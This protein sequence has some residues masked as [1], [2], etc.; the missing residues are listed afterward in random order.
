MAAAPALDRIDFAIIGLL[1]DNGRLS[2]KEIGAS[3]GLAPSSA[4]AR[5]R[6]LREAGVLKGSHEEVDP[7]ALGIGLEALLM[8]ELAKHERATVDSFLDEILQVPEVRSAFLVT[9]RHDLI[10]QVA[11]RDITH[12]KDLALDRFTSRA[13]VTRIETC[14]I[15]EARRQHVLPAFADESA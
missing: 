1:Q 5:L 13:G 4:H 2:M 6:Q 9:G 14:V 11:V 3:I 10:V 8:I 15:Y 7:S 12:L